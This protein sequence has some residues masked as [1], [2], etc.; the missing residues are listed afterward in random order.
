MERNAMSSSS[1]P[2]MLVDRIVEPRIPEAAI[3]D[4]RIDPARLHDIME[5]QR[6]KGLYFY[7][8]DH[9][10]IEAWGALFHE[11]AKLIVDQG[12]QTL[13]ADGNATLVHYAFNHPDIIRTVHHGYTPL[14]AF[15][16]ETEASGIWA[17]AD[18]VQYGVDKT[19]YGY[20]HYR[21]TYRKTDGVWK[22]ASVHLTRLK[23]DMLDDSK[24]GG[25]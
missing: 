11:D 9:R 23:T 14:Y 6:L 7:H 13:I 22:F 18:I 12:E 15:Q 5:L 2:T 3:P 1:K 24:I 16:S 20:G 8:F 17:M 21:E 4:S 19:M 10:N 25:K